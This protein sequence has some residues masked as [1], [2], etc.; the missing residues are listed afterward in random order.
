MALACSLPDELITS[1]VPTDNPY[2][3]TKF[4]CVAIYDSYT[5]VSVITPLFS[6]STTLQLRIEDNYFNFLLIV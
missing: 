4:D 5:I 1:V 6:L 3:I 2:S